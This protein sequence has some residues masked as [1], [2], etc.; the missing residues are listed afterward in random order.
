MWRKEKGLQ[1]VS[2]FFR[3]KYQV[4]KS[5]FIFIW[6]ILQIW[7]I[8]KAYFSS[9]WIIKINLWFNYEDLPATHFVVASPSFTVTLTTAFPSS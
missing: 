9:L 5:V 2:P 6:Y 1:P 8:Y 4:I 7:E 3:R